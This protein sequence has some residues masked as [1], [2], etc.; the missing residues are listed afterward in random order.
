MAE[1]WAGKMFLLLAGTWA[2]GKI[3]LDFGRK[4]PSSSS[5]RA[6]EGREWPFLSLICSY[7][8][9]GEELGG[10]LKWVPSMG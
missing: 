9:L 3:P 4:K 5:A 7:L 6:G 1:L 10:T 8:R 2:G